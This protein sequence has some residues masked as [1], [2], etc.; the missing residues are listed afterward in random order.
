MET[1][2]HFDIGREEEAYR[3]KKHV[4]C[5]DVKRFYPICWTGDFHAVATKD[6]KKVTCEQCKLK[7]ENKSLAK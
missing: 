4:S 3:Q 2:M 5:I 1:L 7:M 6:P